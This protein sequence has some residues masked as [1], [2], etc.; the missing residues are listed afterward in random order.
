M[1]EGEDAGVN[2]DGRS[3]PGVASLSPTV[4]DGE[5]KGRVAGA[6]WVVAVGWSW[7]PWGKILWDG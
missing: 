2:G 7:R 1:A 5:G 4:D 6:V 3:A